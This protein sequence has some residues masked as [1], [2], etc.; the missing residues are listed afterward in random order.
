MQQLVDRISPPHQIVVYIGVG[1]W[2]EDSVEK[3]REGWGRYAT[4]PF[5]TNN[6]WRKSVQWR[7]VV[8]LA[9]FPRLQRDGLAVVTFGRLPTLVRV[10]VGAIGAAWAGA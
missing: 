10:V 7:A 2:G 8:T 1:I 5:Y 6:Q 9:R 3:T 4:T